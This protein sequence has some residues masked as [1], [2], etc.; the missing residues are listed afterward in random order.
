MVYNDASKW[1]RIYRANKSQI[2]KPDLIFPAQ[3]IDV[4]ED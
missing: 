3:V 1:H 2:M 4:P